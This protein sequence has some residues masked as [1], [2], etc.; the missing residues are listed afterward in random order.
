MESLCYSANKGV[1]TP[2][3]SPRPLTERA[4]VTLQVTR[5]PI[6]T[7]DY[8]MGDSM[9]DLQLWSQLVAKCQKT[10]L[11]IMVVANVSQEQGHRERRAV[12]RDGVRCRDRARRHSPPRALCTT[13][14]ERKLDGMPAFTC[15]KLK[16]KGNMMLAMLTLS[17]ESTDPLRTQMIPCHEESQREPHECQTC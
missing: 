1:T 4:M 8:A 5:L 16:I 11:T 13:M 2:T 15:G 14:D 7:G 6:D 10:D 9:S 17:S 12:I 3:T